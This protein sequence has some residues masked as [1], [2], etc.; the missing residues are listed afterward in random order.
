MKVLRGIAYLVLGL[1]VIFSVLFGALY[2]RYATQSTQIHV[3][4]GAFMEQTKS[5]TSE[6]LKPYIHPEFASILDDL[7]KQHRDLF[8]RIANVQEKKHYFSY[9]WKSS[10]GETTTYRGNVMYDTGQFADITIDLVKYSGQWVVYGVDL[11]PKSADQ[12][13]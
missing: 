9:S 11:K 5:G 7:L 6:T 3:T 8:A 4:V 12:T 13:N 2:L 10:V 1:L